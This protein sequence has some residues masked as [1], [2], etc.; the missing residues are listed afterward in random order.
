MYL[1]ALFAALTIT[2][3]AGACTPVH[4]IRSTN[5]AVVESRDEAD[6]TLT[7]LRAGRAALTDPLK[8][9]D[10]AAYVPAAPI[11]LNKRQT[12]P[13]RCPIVFS[14]ASA[15]TVLELGQAVTKTCGLQ[16]RVTPD[17]LNATQLAPAAPV[18]GAPPAGPA[19]SNIP[20]P[21]G[22]SL[23]PP[24][25]AQA[26]SSAAP[27]T[28]SQSLVSLRF[29]GDVTGLLD[30]ATARLGLSWRYANN[31]IT[32]FR[33]DTRFFSIHTIPDQSK[34]QSNITAGTS[35]SSGVQGGGGGGGSGGGGSGSGGISGA[36][37][38]S[39]SSSVSFELDPREDLEKTITSMLT[40]NLGR[41]Y[42]SPFAGGMSVTDT[43]DVL[44]QIAAYV[45]NLNV[46]STRQILIN[47]KVLSVELNNDDEI[48]INWNLIYRSLAD[49]YGIGLVN[50]FG[51][52]DDVITSSVNV[53]EGSSRFS[54]SQLVVNA[55]SKQGRVSVVT[56]P[57]ET[58]LNMKSVT[59]QV[60]DQTSFLA[61]SNT[62]LTADVGAT[63]SM[64]LGTVTTGFTMT[65]LPHILPDGR[66]ILMRFDMAMS[67]LRALRRV[68]SG[69]SLVESPDLKN[70]NT[71]GQ[72]VR[73]NSGETLV[74]S[75]F[76]QVT[77]STDSAGVGN[78]FNW[79]FG[80]GNRN[81]KKREVLVVLISPVVTS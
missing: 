37:T 11:L 63:T 33:V 52:S 67:S 3:L 45:D 59:V 39:Q 49:N 27:V 73:L 79:I 78:P 21:P 62:T 34:L 14:P 30:A 55:L 50:S 12:L 18:G 5:A 16:V 43:P 38:S 1:R 47:V 29:S 19:A 41:M 8:I 76:E 10:S 46:F 23:P 64:Q 70:K 9:V 42:Y 44:D 20:L 32:I 7:S 56:Q 53:L 26:Y 4:N 22:V 72:M 61:S 60:G 69:D 54:G 17:A 15:V 40:P 48:G 31:I 25:G 36:S 57:S 80:G 24:A 71:S 66:T 6:A 2:L 75:G 68:E 65:V 51:V 58:T 28:A 81:S 77:N 74:L 35:T 13:T